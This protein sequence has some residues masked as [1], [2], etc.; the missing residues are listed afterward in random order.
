MDSVQGPLGA[1]DGVKMA[2][3]RLFRPKTGFTEFGWRCKI[4]NKEGENSFI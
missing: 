4:S 3:S 2:L 1:P